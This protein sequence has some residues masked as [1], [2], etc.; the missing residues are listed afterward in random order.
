MTVSRRYAGPS[1]KFQINI[2]AFA[3]WLIA[4]K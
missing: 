2:N 4:D 3:E 1:G